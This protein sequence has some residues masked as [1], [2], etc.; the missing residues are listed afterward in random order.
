MK[1]RTI[2]FIS[3]LFALA[4]TVAW[5]AAQ[6]HGAQTDLAGKLIRLHVLAHSDS[7]EDQAL[8]ETVRDAVLKYARKELKGCLGV[9]EAETVLEGSL[10]ELEA[11]ATAVVAAQG[12]D[13]SV[14]VTLTWEDYPT[15]TYDTFALPAGRYLSLRIIL[16][17]G[18][19]KNWWCVVFPPLCMA[20][21][22]EEF[23]DR[24]EAA[25]LTEEEISLITRESQGYEVRFKLIEWIEDWLR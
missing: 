10:S 18:A 11:V 16:G 5:T 2:C 17:E 22:T 24:A 25:G 1:K 13:E 19:G 7:E 12:H 9:E 4:I 8:K 23:S 14:Q 21:T 20:A 6:A 3:L 15:R